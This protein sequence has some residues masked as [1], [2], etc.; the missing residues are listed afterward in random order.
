[1]GRLRSRARPRFRLAD[2]AKRILLVST[3]PASN[4][5]EMLGTALSNRPTPIAGVERLLAL[6]IDPEQAAA[7]YRERVIGPYR[8]IWTDA[9]LAELAEQLAGACT[10]EI[11][12]FDEFAELLAG[13]ETSVPFDHVLPWMAEEPIGPER[14]LALACSHTAE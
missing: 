11:A 6:N 2:A 9:Q 4:L 12:A 10:T 8:S 14:L 3:D 1:M 5:D 7:E 13:D